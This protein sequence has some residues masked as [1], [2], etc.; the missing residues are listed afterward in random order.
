MQSKYKSTTPAQ[1]H[2]QILI[3]AFNEEVELYDMSYRYGASSER[4]RA[5]P[6]RTGG[7]G[8]VAS[9]AIVCFIEKGFAEVEARR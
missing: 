2:P 6:C 7:A 9:R 5:L 4:A 3:H 8:F 1:Q